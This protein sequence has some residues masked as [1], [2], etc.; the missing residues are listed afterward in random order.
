MM[1][2]GV[3]L[4]GRLMRDRVQGMAIDAF[5]QAMLKLEIFQGLKPLQITEIARRA[6]RVVY[7]PGD[8]IIRQDEDGDAAVIVVSGDAVRISGPGLSEPAEPVPQ[9]SL[10]GEMAMLIETQHTSTVIAR[11]TV[12]AL[13]ISREELQAQMADDSS[14]ADHF[15]QRITARLSTVL[16]SLKAIDALVVE[17]SMV[18]APASR[19]GIASHVH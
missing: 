8:F 2:A 3:P 9:G 1:K 7:K 11:N 12:R 6:Y 13:R 17:A 4:S 16:E 5:V 10:L 18:P 19:T 15:V 14:L